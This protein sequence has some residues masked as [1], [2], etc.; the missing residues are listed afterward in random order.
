MHQPPK[1]SYLC[2]CG[3]ARCREA[4]EEAARRGAGGGGARPYG[5][6]DGRGAATPLCPSTRDALRTVL[7]HTGLSTQPVRGHNRDISLQADIM[8][9]DRS[10]KEEH[11]EPGLSALLSSSHLSCKRRNLPPELPLP[12]PV[13]ALLQLPAEPGRHS[14]P[15]QSSWKTRGY[16]STI[17]NQKLEFKAQS[18]VGSMDNVKHKPGGGDIK[19]FD[20]KEYAKQMSGQSPLPGSYSHSAQ[21]S[22]E[23]HATQTPKSDENL[24]QQQC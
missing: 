14:S 15:L 13:L 7:N 17:D 21:E 10:S 1:N 8:P 18:K 5:S 12:V 19:I 4:E 3:L 11:G 16:D 9:E 6:D 2:F 22:P 24:N 23:P 20:D